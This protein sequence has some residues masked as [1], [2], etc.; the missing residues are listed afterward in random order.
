MPRLPHRL[1]VAAGLVFLSFGGPL[2]AAPDVVA[3]IAPVHGIAARIMQGGASEP[4]LLLPPGAS[5]HGYALRPSDAAA[6]AEADVVFWIGP[7]LETFLEKPL[8][9]LAAKAAVT[10]LMA[11]EGI[12][13]LEYRDGDF[14]EDDGHEHDHGRDHA[15]ERDHG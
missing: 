6:L 10:P 11:A 14:A 4:R 1:A 8:Q 15:H 7:A 12:R 3:S 5:P 13:L 9:A 2:Q